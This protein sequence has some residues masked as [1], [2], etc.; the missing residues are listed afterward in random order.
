MHALLEDIARIPFS[1]SGSYIAFSR[2]GQFQWKEMTFPAGIWMRSV[3]G[4]GA[5]ELMHFDLIQDGVPI[6]CS[7]HASASM[8][9]LQASSEGYVQIIIPSES[10]VRVRICGVSL[11]IT[12]R[13]F[14]NH[15]AIPEPTG[16]W[17]F[18]LA[19]AFRSYRLIP[20]KGT[21]S[22]DA[23]WGIKQC[24]RI[25]AELKPPLHDDAELAIEEL[26]WMSPPQKHDVSF[27]ALAKKVQAEYEGFAKP[28]VN[29]S[30]A[31]DDPAS[32]AAY[33]NWSSIVAPC[34]RLQRPTMLMSKNW[35]TNVWAWDHA[36]NALATCISDPNLA[37]DQFMVIFDHQNESG[38]IPD[39][40]NDMRIMT[41]FVKPPIHGWILSRMLDITGGISEERM[42]DAYRK[43][44]QWTKW[45]FT[46]RVPD[47][48]GL[49][50]Y[51]H[52]ND[53]GW[54]NGSV[55][56]VG[57]PVKSPDLA[58]FLIVQMDLLA[59]FAQRFD[60][61]E[62][63]EL[64]RQ[65]AERLLKALL[66]TL[67]DGARFQCRH[68][69]SGR[70]NEQSDSVFGCLPIILGTRL[71]IEVLDSLEQEIRRHLTEWGVSTENVNS[72]L[73]QASGYWRGPI[74]AP[75]TLILVDGL[76]RSGKLELAQD[77]A[78]RF[79]A[80]CTKNGFAE[81]F[82]ATTGKPLCD[83]A[84]TWTSSVFLVLATQYL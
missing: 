23:P 11:R 56:D 3:H 55:F 21:L 28:Y 49:P 40:I 15:G 67:W 6:P 7:T 18:Q 31:Y 26:M 2:L 22:V 84:Y 32:Q 20:L 39:F 69:P 61:L 13:L 29:P 57:F 76:V 27:N 33:L 58:A 53:S 81:N 1:R 30:S 73:Y 80:L 65:N 74:W 64:W 82:D 83:P 63:V 24:S 38:Q 42:R 68:A 66:S 48:D 10:T 44:A 78:E 37:W 14:R 36:F 59:K 72:P 41:N 12:A 60:L 5:Y 17:V 19:S 16:N 8:L 43:L 62:D 9:T 46:F 4:D 79:C 71:P 25:V 75:S 35:M 52:G 70:V 47:A 54:D 51:W 45:W 77:I 50:T 34:G